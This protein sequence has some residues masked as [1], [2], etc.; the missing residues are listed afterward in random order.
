M[1]LNL[2]VSHFDMQAYI[3]GKYRVYL[4]SSTQ[5]WLLFIVFDIHL[6]VERTTADVSSLAFAVVR[7]LKACVVAA[8]ACVTTCLV[9]CS[10][11]TANYIKEYLGEQLTLLKRPV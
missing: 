11:A 3:T 6:A 8:A 7:A 1:N 4:S 5:A 2:F 9:F 10:A